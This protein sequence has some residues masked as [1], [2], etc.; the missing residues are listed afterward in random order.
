MKNQSEQ[1]QDDFLI[2]P[3]PIY[4]VVFRYLMQDYDSALIILSTLINEKIKRLD[5]QPLT[6]AKKKTNEENSQQTENLI[7]K[8]FEKEKQKIL[9]R[10]VLPNQECIRL[11]L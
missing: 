4:D 5:F 7:N 10:I 8:R 11:E 2:I 6:H 9:G 1:D 3:N